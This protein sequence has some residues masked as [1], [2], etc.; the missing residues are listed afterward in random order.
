MNKNQEYF[1]ICKTFHLNRLSKDSG[2][3]TDV[4]REGVVQKP[5]RN[6]K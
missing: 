4:F 5:K 6:A 2:L 3:Q 1:A